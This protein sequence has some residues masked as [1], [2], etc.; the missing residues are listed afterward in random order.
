MDPL[1]IA[2]GIWFLEVAQ[3]NSWL[4]MLA[5][6]LCAVVALAMTS[7]SGNELLGICFECYIF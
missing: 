4:V 3:H 2:Y 5:F 1:K 6:L 7:N